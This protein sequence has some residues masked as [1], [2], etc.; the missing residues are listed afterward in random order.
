MTSFT[1]GSS[2]ES[3]ATTDPQFPT[4]A[5]SN[6]EVP[7]RFTLRLTYGHNFFKDLESRF[8]LY[9]VHEEGEP[10]SFVMDGGE[11]SNPFFARHLLYVPTDGNDPAVVFGDGFDQ[12]AFFSW[13]DSQGLARGAF[14]ERNAKHA[15][16]TTRADFLF[17]QEVWSDLAKT[18]GKFFLKIYNLT[19]LLNDS[20]GHIEQG[21]F[22]PLQV[23]SGGVNDQGQYTFDSFRPQFVGDI[24]EQR[25]LWEARI[26]FEV[27]F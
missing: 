21:Q 3:V 1:A 24:N 25:S 26:G 19:N 5:T 16:W 11:P 13:A 17:T 18:R 27:N 22:F 20:W 10:Q 12:A 6:W 14:V 15:G 9:A 8:T 23:V 7:N 2:Y 4:P